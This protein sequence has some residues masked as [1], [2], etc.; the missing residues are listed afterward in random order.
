ME[1]ENKPLIHTFNCTKCG[2]EMNYYCVS[3]P[4]KKCPCITCQSKE[5]RKEK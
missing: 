4:N 2:R 1:K 5:L 3:E